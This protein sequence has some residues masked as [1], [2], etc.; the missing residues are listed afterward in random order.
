MVADV[1]KDPR[2]L[3]TFGSTQ[4]EIVVPVITESEKVVGL[5]DV[6]SE[7]LNA[8]TRSGSGFPRAR[9]LSYRARPGLEVSSPALEVALAKW[10]AAGLRCLGQISIA[11]E[12]DGSLLPDSS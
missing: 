9:G 8:F 12:K 7:K 10:L 3:P 11:E 1:H 6:E 5:I 2:Y 4:S